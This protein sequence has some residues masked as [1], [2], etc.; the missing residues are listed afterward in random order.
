MSQENTTVTSLEQM[1]QLATDF[2]AEHSAY[3]AKGTKAASKRL[4]AHMN[5][6]KKLATSAK[7]ELI[8]ADAQP[9]AE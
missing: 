3:Q 5:E 8:E 2:L 9:K 6:M 4:R 1:V 7:K